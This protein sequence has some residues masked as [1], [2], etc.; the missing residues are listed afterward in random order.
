MSKHS[1]STDELVSSMAKQLLQGATMTGDSCP[2]CNT[3]LF[4]NKQ[5]T[6]FCPKCERPVIIVDSLEEVPQE[7]SGDT[8]HKPLPST[9]QTGSLTEQTVFTQ[10]QKVL[11]SKIQIFTNTMA[12]TSDPTK[13]RELLSVLEELHK[14]YSQLPKTITEK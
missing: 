13:L 12:S 2:N 11:L 4:R 6:L 7:H 1:K 9:N 8:A 3:P 10:L 14:V 5:G